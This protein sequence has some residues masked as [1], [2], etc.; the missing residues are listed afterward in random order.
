M[1]ITTKYIKESDKEL[2][3]TDLFYDGEYIG[4]IMKSSGKFCGVNAQWWFVYSNGSSISARTK[5]EL[6]EKVEYMMEGW[7]N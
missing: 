5:K 6:C 1:R 7:S 2:A 3:H 4:Y